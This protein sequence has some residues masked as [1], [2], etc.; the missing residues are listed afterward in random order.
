MIIAFYLADK[1]FH[2][3]AESFER[4]LGLNSRKPFTRTAVMREAGRLPQHLRTSGSV[5]KY[6]LRKVAEDYLP[7]DIIYGVKVTYD[8]VKHSAYIENDARWIDYLSGLRNGKSL[9]FD[10]LE[11]KIIGE[12]IERVL[13]DVN[14]DPFFVWRLV[15]LDLW[16]SN[17]QDL[18][19]LSL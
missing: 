11:Q 2:T 4:S 3:K 8:S 18:E 15:T 5:E 19:E 13:Q 1:I 6:I 17:I 12:K 10:C 9:L 14:H 7:K 16:S